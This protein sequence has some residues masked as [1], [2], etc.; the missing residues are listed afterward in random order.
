AYVSTLRAD[1]LPE[2]VP[3]NRRKDLQSNAGVFPLGILLFDPANWPT[4]A[5][6]ILAAEVLGYNVWMN[7]ISGVST[8]AASEPFY[9]VAGCEQNLTEW[10]CGG[11]V[12]RT[13][14]ALSGAYLPGNEEVLA[15]VQRLRVGGIMDVQAD[16]GN[17]I[18]EGLSISQRL[19]D[20]V[21]KETGLALE[22]F[23]SYH[24][25]NKAAILP[26]FHKIQDVNDSDLAPCATWVLWPEFSNRMEAYLQITGDA[27]GVTVEAE[28]G[29]QTIRPRCHES[30]WWL[31]PTC[32]ENSTECI[33]CL[34]YDWFG[35]PWH[36]E[37]V[38]QKATIWEMPLAIGAALADFNSVSGPY[39]RLPL[40][41]DVVT[42]RQHPDLQNTI[43]LVSAPIVFPRH[44]PRDW[45]RGLASSMSAPWSTSRLSHKDLGEWA[46]DVQELLRR[47]RFYGEDYEYV[48]IGM[49]G[50][51][52]QGQATWQGLACEWL[53]NNTDVW[54]AWVPAVTSCFPGHG[55]FGA[56]TFVSSRENATTCRPCPP[57]S[58]SAPFYDYEET[59]QCQS[60]SPGY[61]QS[62]YG[63]VT[64]NPCS[65]GTFANDTGSTL[66][67]DCAQGQFQPAASSSSCEV[68]DISQTTN[69][70]GATERSEC[71]CKSGYFRGATGC[72]L[73]S[74]GLR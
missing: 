37:E 51:V 54:K 6:E 26:Y 32:R 42:L 74:T 17:P 21:L 52:E 3:P 16:I 72:E 19:A 13:H 22:Y 47:M 1:C 23:R 65:P 55:L 11:Q 31:A 44:S 28:G 46:P 56:G 25:R 36:I 2:A 14:V 59:A 40:T 12:S 57:G 49:S 5:L 34:L 50:R 27:D 39:Y 9:L 61:W 62:S 33:P 8:F 18:Y 38:M 70:R 4:L 58:Y 24:V 7:D 30:R 69:I 43:P 73:C 71:I 53:Q 10:Q 41:H 45:Q 68:C 20:K 35:F 66:C 15:K 67:N 64:C 63:T 48:S 29:T 60:C